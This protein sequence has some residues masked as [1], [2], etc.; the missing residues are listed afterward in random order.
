M[1]I[2]II[3]LIACLYLLGT[4]SG[5]HIL[6][7]LMKKFSRVVGYIIVAV[8]IAYLIYVIIKLIISNLW[9]LLVILL[10]LFAILLLLSCLTAKDKSKNPKS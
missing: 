7:V 9:A 1:L 5:R 8:L 10:L 2:K 3:A 4:K 6:S